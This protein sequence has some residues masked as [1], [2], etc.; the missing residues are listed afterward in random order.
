[1]TE[2][3]NEVRDKLR[4]V[5][6]YPEEVDE[7]VV[8]AVDQMNR[9]EHRVYVVRKGSTSGGLGPLSPGYDGNITELGTF[10]RITS[11]LSWSAEG[12][13]EV[14]ILAAWS[15]RCR[16]ASISTSRSPGASP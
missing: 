12:V 13:S 9:D 16:S 10:F 11:N 4:Q 7:L 3:M 6:R 2:A 15:A 8:E 1:M 14:Q 5:P